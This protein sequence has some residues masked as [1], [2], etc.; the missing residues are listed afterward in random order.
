MNTEQNK[1]DG[2]TYELRTFAD[3]YNLPSIDHI[4]RCLPELCQVILATRGAADLL[5]ACAK[6]VNSN[7]PAVS[8]SDAVEL[9]EVVEWKDDGAGTLELNFRHEGKTLM[10]ISNNDDAP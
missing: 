1:P 6:E 2:K 10:T 9:P 7:M 3:V 4:R 5:I 8:A